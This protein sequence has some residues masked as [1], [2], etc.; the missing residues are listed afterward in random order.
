MI[1]LSI[2]TTNTTHHCYFVQ[3]VK[4][5]ELEV[6]VIFEPPKPINN[7]VLLEQSFE[8]Q[9]KSFEEKRV[10]YENQRWFEGKKMDITNFTNVFKVDDI[11]SKNAHE[12]LK[13]INPDLIVVFGTR[14]I[15]EDMISAFKNRIF[16]LHGGSP[17]KYRGLDSHYWAIYHKDFESITTTL[18]QVES[19]LDTGGII[20]QE[21][22]KL[23][24]N[25]NL[26]Q[27]RASNTELCVYLTNELIDIFKKNKSIKSKKQ[28]TKG[29]YYSLMPE[30]LKSNIE[31]KFQNYIKKI[32]S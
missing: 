17:E 16:N 27:L 9:K 18:H 7:S 25:M 4:K 26:Y 1:K 11:N 12:K 29:R 13:E 2:L 6:S 15:K 10:N 28:K 24:P 32:S 22:V 21:K 5:N 31:F 30:A 3:E 14:K 19:S 23:W 20:L 8:N